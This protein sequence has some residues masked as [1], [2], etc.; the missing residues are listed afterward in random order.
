M[1]KLMRLVLLCLV[2]SASAGAADESGMQWLRSDRV[3]FEQAAKAQRPV[4]L[5]LEAVWCHWCHVMD[6]ET[7]ADPEVRA[8]IEQHFVALRIDQ[9][10]RPDLANRY[11]DY[12]WPATI[13][14]A[15]DGTELAKRQGFVPTAAFTKLLRSVR[16]PFGLQAEASSIPFG[17]I[18]QS[19]K[20]TMNSSGQLTPISGKP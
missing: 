5:Y 3:A 9:D 4:I 7:Y 14:F 18:I 19:P 10:L 20:F 12:G 13:I 1:R 16:D 17:E 2:L 6:R 11:R 15:P 8:L